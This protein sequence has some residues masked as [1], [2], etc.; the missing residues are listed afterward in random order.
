MRVVVEQ[1]HTR[2]FSDLGWLRSG[3]SYSFAEYRNRNRMGFGSLRVF[4]DDSI[5]PNKG[6][7]MH[8]H[9]DM[10]I[11][12]VILKGSI[13][14]E[15]SMGHKSVLSAPSIQKMSAGTGIYHSEFNA[16]E[17][18]EL[19]LFQIW[20]HPHTKGLTPVYEQKEITKEEFTNKLLALVEPKPKDNSIEIFQN[21]KISRGYWDKKDKI[22]YKLSVGNG[23]FL[24]VV[25]GIVTLD[26]KTLFE[27]D[28][29]QISDTQEINI[30]MTENSEILLIEVQI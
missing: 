17:S 26:D 8:P 23:I 30:E 16:S 11:V 10:E 29:A 4:N 1:A 18:E 25:S 6:F 27:R 24:F 9:A 21:A 13:A 2:G 3:F 12:T 20:I 5:A 7:G 14:H 28:S 22:N 15:D 19:K